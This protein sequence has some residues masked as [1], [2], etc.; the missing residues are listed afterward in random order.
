MSTEKVT[1]S[2]DRTALWMAK[3][4]A[5]REGVSLSLWL[6]RAVRR[7]ALRQDAARHRLSSEAL[8]E[9]EREA[10]LNEAEIQA[11]EEAERDWRAAG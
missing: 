9:A 2:V 5:G 10:E 6:S 4:S 8:R 7:E 1:L 11:V 3:Q